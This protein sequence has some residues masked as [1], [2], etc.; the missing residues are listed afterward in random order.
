[1]NDP[2]IAIVYFNP[3]AIKHKK[4]DYIDKEEV[5]RSF[6]RQ[7]LLIFT[8]SV[9]LEKY[10]K[11]LNHSNK[12]ILMMSSGNFNGINLNMIIKD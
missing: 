5:Y 10:L 6:N 11:S 4:L 8:D 9:K 3:E 12:N 2:D 1:M 7:D